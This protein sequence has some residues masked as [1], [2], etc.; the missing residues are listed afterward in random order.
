MLM[1]SG[2]PLGTRQYLLDEPRTIARLCLELMRGR[3]TAPAQSSMTVE[4]DATE[5]H[6][7]GRVLNAA[8]E[9]ASIAD[10]DDLLKSAVAFARDVIGLEHVAFFARDATPRRLRLRGCWSVAADGEIVDASGR[11]HE[12]GA[13]EHLALLRLRHAGQ[14][15]KQLAPQDIPG[16]LG[17][18]PGGV[19]PSWAVATPLFAG[20]KLVA[21]LYNGGTTH[22][23]VVETKQLEAA[24]LCSSIGTLLLP[25]RH[26][27]AWRASE[28]PGPRS[29][30]VERTLAA[31]AETPEVRGRVL[32]RRF[33]MSPGHLARTFK[34]EVGISLVEHRHRVLIERFFASLNR[35]SASLVDAAREAGFGSYAQFHRVY[36]KLMRAT[37]Y[38]SLSR[39]RTAELP[40]E[41]SLSGSKP[42]SAVA[43]A[44]R[45]RS[46]LDDVGVRR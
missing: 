5:L 30:A 46:G 15:W 38:E 18:H 31:I 25:H 28:R 24:V 16:P 40:H 23:P 3:P 2:E 8:S 13:P 27:L 21:V 43:D 29:I 34:R 33:G 1:G 26:R 37:P 11:Y 7:L 36:R 6:P 4:A 22:T 41:A 17:L 44:R 19:Q 45:L 35:G 9:L 39:P 10:V 20:R 12:Y 14:L 32:A 42:R